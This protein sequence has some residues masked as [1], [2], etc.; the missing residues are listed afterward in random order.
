MSPI[1]TAHSGANSGS[2]SGFTSGS[3]SGH[4]AD[5]TAGSAAALLS[6][7]ALYSALR[8]TYPTA[9]L[10][11]EL[12]SLGVT[13]ASAPPSGYGVRAVV[14]TEH[15]VL[16][17]AMAQGDSLEAAEDRACRRVLELL[18][19]HCWPEDGRQ[20]AGQGGGVPGGVRQGGAVQG[21]RG[22]MGA[23]RE[24]GE[25]GSP[26]PVA[27]GLDTGA[28]VE[29]SAV[30]ADAVKSGST[31]ANPPTHPEAVAP[32]L[33]FDAPHSTN[34]H[35]PSA[36][37]DG[38][39]ADA[40]LVDGSAADTTSAEVALATPPSI[41]PS[42]DTPLDVTPANPSLVDAAPLDSASVNATPI[43]LATSPNRPSPPATDGVPTAGLSPEPAPPL[44]VVP[45]PD[46]TP[47]LSLV[48]PLGSPAPT[49]SPSSTAAAPPAPAPPTPLP[50]VED[51]GESLAQ[52]DVEVRRLGWT[53]QQEA[54]YLQAHYGHP[55]RDYVTEYAEL[56][57]LIQALKAIPSP[58]P[59]SEPGSGPIVDPFPVSSGIAPWRPTP[60][61]GHAAS[62]A[63]PAAPAV[64]QPTVVSSPGSA[65]SGDPV[66]YTSPPTW[67]TA[68]VATVPNP[69]PTPS[70]YS[71]PDP[72]AE[73]PPTPIPPAIAGLSRSEMMDQ[74]LVE[75]ERLGWTPQ[76]GKDYLRQAYG[77]TARSQLTNDELREF[78]T[79][80]GNLS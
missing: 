4:Q 23:D 12:L 57:D 26:T 20:G 67:E 35:R 50:A 34:G 38:V 69:S 43:P 41:P 3:D 14:R 17:T 62:V 76:Q 22:A 24:A 73:P 48:P 46:S 15:L 79:Y 18:G 13:G 47:T 25:S 5:A 65:A 1:S 40:A 32:L 9:G 75:C 61:P 78:L 66:T 27:R 28:P 6:L 45:P 60:D 7:T 63:T 68:P 21:G 42:I 52:L 30:R 29:E 10:E 80:L 36:S 59:T 74:V 39:P 70:P 51:W 54:D 72:P 44:S 58:T 77:K 33:N 8:A 53:P 56:L 19:L 31:P 55:S 49:A 2:T 64:P 71:E 11:T 37:A 16:A